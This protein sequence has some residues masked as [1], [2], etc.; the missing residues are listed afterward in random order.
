MPQKAAP[1]KKGRTTVTKKSSSK[2]TKG[3]TYA[4]E[5]CGLVVTVDEDCECTDSCEI[6]CC[7]TQMK[8]RAASRKKAAPAKKPAASKK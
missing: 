4:C 8:P 5:V 1:A 3:Q 7:N 6:I 2:P